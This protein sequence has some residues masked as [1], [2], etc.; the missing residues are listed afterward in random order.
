M[1]IDP[2]KATLLVPSYAEKNEARLGEFVTCLGKNLNCDSIG[3]V[4]L[5][6]EET[7]EDYDAWLT[8][9]DTIAH[10]A[11]VDALRH[12]RLER[13]EHGKP[14]SYR[15]GFRIGNEMVRS[16]DVVIMANADIY[17][18][19]SLERVDN[20]ALTKALV[21]LSRWEEGDYQQPARHGG[22][23][24]WIWRTPVPLFPADYLLGQFGGD[25]RLPFDARK[26]GLRIFNPAYSI[27]S[28]HLHLSPLHKR[29][30]M[31]EVPGPYEWTAA[32]DGMGNRPDPGKSGLEGIRLKMAR[33]PMYRRGEARLL[34]VQREGRVI[35]HRRV[36]D[37]VSLLAGRTVYVNDT[38]LRNSRIEMY[39]D[40]GQRVEVVLLE[41]L[42]P[43]RWEV[44]IRGFQRGVKPG[45]KLWTRD[46]I[47]ATVL[48][49]SDYRW[50][51]I[52]FEESPDLATIGTPTY[53]KACLEPKNGEGP[54]YEPL[55]AAKPGSL[56]AASA[57]A[58]LSRA[59]LDAIKPRTLTL[60]TGSAA[61]VPVNQARLAREFRAES[62]SVPIVPTEPS[63]AVGTSTVRALEASVRTGSEGRT[64]L[65]IHGDFRFKAT[66]GI[67]TSLHLFGTPDFLLVDSFLGRDLVETVYRTAAERGYL[68]SA[69]GDS[70]LAL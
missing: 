66:S 44:F 8:S 50:Y 43:N 46:S 32:S 9:S 28:T 12:D 16:G 26:A 6:I 33:S 62:Y 65:F 34:V 38:K 42:G 69:Y 36:S 10:R 14:L 58:N 40:S 70:M 51:Q 7:T 18:D 45:S 2:F 19:T 21:C 20:F 67:L 22:A 24:S 63:V 68:F 25:L 5:V 23:D 54:L 55:Y 4:L 53:P 59:V 3:R 17:F 48:S 29:D 61:V 15:D 49:G 39:L 31:D 57:G 11:L 37:L 30:G 64:D 1:S 47:A 60:H 27:R 13:V 56:L 52:E 35:E 41:E